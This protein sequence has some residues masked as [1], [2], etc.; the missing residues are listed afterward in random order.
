MPKSKEQSGYVFKRPGSPFYYARWWI[1]GKEYVQTTKKKTKPEAEAEKDLLVARSRGEYSV[2]DA[3]VVVLN[4]LAKIEDEQQ[5]ESIRRTLAKRLMGGM[6]DKIAVE[7]AWQAW[8]TSPNKK[9][10]PKASTVAGYEAIWK[11]FKTWAGQ[12]SLEYLHEVDRADAERY[13]ED[14]WKSHVSPSTFNAHIKLLTNI[15]K[16]LETSAG[17][18]ENVWARITR[19]E[20]TPDQGRRNL[21]EKELQTIFEKATGNRKM[22]LMLGLFTGLRLGD[23]VNLR[24]ADIDT[25]PGFIVVVPMKVSRLGKAK[26]V[27]L[28]VHPALQRALSE[29]RSR[30]DGEFLFPVER[31]LYAANAANVTGP[32]QEFFQSCGIVTNEAVENGERRRAIVRV[33]FHSMRHS[34]V[35]LCAKA[36]APQ[37]VVQRLVGHGSPAMTEHYTHLD[38]GQKQD[39]I[40]A[41]PALGFGSVRTKKRER[42]QNPT[43]VPAN[44][45]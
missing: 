3:F 10:T 12:N 39:A 45:N 44:S 42:S 24:W 22:M 19:K 14:L 2:E 31:E 8:T 27:E 30:T 41:L 5:R 1:D 34:F 13:A 18:T 32:M 17:L 37:H 33:G 38:D 23:V 29:H 40:R 25:K 11:R 28:P 7:S 15:F 6:K 16:I 4:S 26:K 43:D 9:R 35:S 36:G 20:K 21:S